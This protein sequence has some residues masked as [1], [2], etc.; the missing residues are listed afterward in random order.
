MKKLTALTI[1]LILAFSIAS[2]GITNASVEKG[3]KISFGG[4]DWIVLD[5]VDDKALVLSDK[6][7]DK[8][9]YHSSDV[10]IAW[11][12]SEIR[13]YL[14]GE[15]YENTFSAKEKRKIIK[16]EIVNK[17]SNRTK[18]KVFLLS[19][20]EAVRYFNGDSKRIAFELYPGSRWQWWLRSHGDY[21]KDATDRSAMSVANDGRIVLTGMPVGTKTIGV[22]PALWM[23]M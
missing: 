4:Y 9:N 1:V 7:I 22:R 2:F 15:F 6:V 8:R 11:E 13:R 21:S 18:D 3:A 17:D 19:F 10:P 5:V 14:N 20:E 12:N 23:K 16:T